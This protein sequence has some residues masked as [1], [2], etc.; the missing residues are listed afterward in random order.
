MP[1][2]RSITPALGVGGVLLIAYL[3]LSW[4]PPGPAVVWIPSAEM[5]LL[6]R[7]FPGVPPWWPAVRLATLLGGAVLAALA[8]PPPRLPAIELPAA[9]AI[10][11]RTLALAFCLALAQLVSVPLLEPL[12]RWGQ[13]GYLVALYL[14]GLVLW[15]GEETRPI[16]KRP[17]GA[18]AAGC[19]AAWCLWILW[20]VRENPRAASTGD[21]W[22]L[23]EYLE[24]V[25]QSQQNLM[26]SW[27]QPWVAAS[28]ILATP[29]IL[30]GPDD[31]P[32]LAAMEI[33]GIAWIAAAAW[34]TA[35]SLRRCGYVRTSIVA[36]V[37]VLFAPISLTLTFWSFSLAFMT[38][39]AA[40]L[41]RLA[42]AFRERGSMAV[43]AW[44]G[45]T[46]G[47]TFFQGYVAFAPIAAVVVVFA[48]AV[49]RD[50][51][52]GAPMAIACL[53]F[54]SATLPFVGSIDRGEFRSEIS[55]TVWPWSVVEQIFYE[56]H[57]PLLGQEQAGALERTGYANRVDIAISGLLSPFLSP[58]TAIRLLGDQLL[59]PL[60]AAL[61]A[62]GLLLASRAGRR[63]WAWI[64]LWVW[65]QLPVIATTNYD[66]ISPLRDLA[67]PVVSAPFVVMAVESLGLVITASALPV[68]IAAVAAVSGAVVLTEIQPRTLAASAVEILLEAAGRE[69]DPKALVMLELL[70]V[71][72]QDVKLSAFRRPPRT[73]LYRH[74]GDLAA[75]AASD[76]ATRAIFWSPMLEVECD[77]ASAIC[78]LWP[79]ATVYTV[80]DR[81]HL[82][83]TFAVAIG[84]GASWVPLLAPERWEAR[85]CTPELDLI[86]GVG[87]H[88]VCSPA[89]L[90]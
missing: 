35:S 90:G 37:T 66:R 26:T 20:E 80:Y 57:A 88:R 28:S 44:I 9:P 56:Q 59:E 17:R 43:L 49:V 48:W 81:A 79:N 8:L 75:I 4:Q 54:L 72:S 14:P 60:T 55:G 10:R 32:S 23:Y 21:V 73:A 6:Q 11:P 89:Q 86:P 39:L 67:L 64:S 78:G 38:A 29:A 2:R 16:P 27:L 58:R 83:R 22:V 40:V 52:Y 5:S 47:V 76:A 1:I 62:V 24:A 87:E 46:A 41:L 25:L 3:G 7:L 85:P 13:I 63:G 61:T 33:S 51:R 19:I 71:E 18:V 53:C 74:R 65:M 70:A 69:P 30:S 12:P 34:L 82:S 50:R 77:L 31:L 42:V 45:A 15:I 68:V 84:S 36:A